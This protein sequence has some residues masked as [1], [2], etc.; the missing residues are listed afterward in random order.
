MSKDIRKDLEHKE[1]PTLKQI[2]DLTVQSFKSQEWE[3]D[4]ELRIPYTLLSAAWIV[5]ENLIQDGVDPHKLMASLIGS[6]SLIPNQIDG[7][8]SVGEA[9]T[10]EDLYHTVS[11]RIVEAEAF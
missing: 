11:R 3:M 10:W 4:G 5:T 8:E 6:T 2:V 9:V 7:F 1:I